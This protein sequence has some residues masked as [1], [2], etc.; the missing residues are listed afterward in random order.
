MCCSVLHDL[1]KWS[2]IGRERYQ[3]RA[4]TVYNP[5]EGSGFARGIASAKLHDDLALELS[6]GWF[7][8]GG[9]DVIGRFE[10]SDFTYARL[11]YYF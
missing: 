6:A 4:F 10:D 2:A 1:F 3:L 7:A 11:K 9:R 5:P 8:G